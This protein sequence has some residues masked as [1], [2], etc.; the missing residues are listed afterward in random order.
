MFN[1]LRFLWVLMFGSSHKPKHGHDDDEGCESTERLLVR[2][3][4]LELR[5]DRAL[6]RRLL[7]ILEHIPRAT[8]VRILFIRNSQGDHMADPI[9]IQIGQTIAAKV[10]VLD[11]NGALMPGFD[12]VAN[13]PAFAADNANVSVGPG[14]SPDVSAV[15]G[16]NAGDANVSVTVPGVTNGTD[17]G[18]VTVEAAASVATSV[19]LSFT[20]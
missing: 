13:P 5:E 15:T 12:F 17:S 2:E 3:L 10:E 6:I 20:T 4:I 18:V 19:R 1:P 9:K 8:H 11:Q 7:A 16:A 14:A